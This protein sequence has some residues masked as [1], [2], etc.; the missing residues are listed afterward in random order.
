[1]PV[2][3]ILPSGARIAHALRYACPARDIRQVAAIRYRAGWR[4]EEEHGLTGVF[5]SDALLRWMFCLI[6]L[7]ELLTQITFTVAG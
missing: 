1:M 7:G 6:D 2:G 3:D 4:L 5:L